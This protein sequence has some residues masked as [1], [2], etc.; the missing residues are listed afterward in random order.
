[1]VASVDYGLVGCPWPS[2]QTNRLLPE[3]PLLQ[4]ELLFPSPAIAALL[5]MDKELFGIT[6]SD[7]R[8]QHPYVR[9]HL[10]QRS[11][12]LPWRC[13][14]YPSPPELHC[15]AH[16]NRSS[17]RHVSHS[18]L[19]L[20]RARAVIMAMMRF[21]RNATYSVSGCWRRHVG[22]RRTVTLFYD[23]GS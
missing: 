11:S 6:Q 14:C 22:L 12:S 10:N 1:M 16:F 21:G 19:S 4:P 18:L 5:G 15:R 17:F 8:T 7:G 13:Y 3:P 9:L 23:D 2:T 20:S